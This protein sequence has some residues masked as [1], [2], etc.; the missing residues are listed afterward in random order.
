MGS[1]GTTVNKA[2]LLPTLLSFVVIFS[3]TLPASATGTS[4]MPVPVLEGYATTYL[5]ADSSNLGLGMAL[6]SPQREM[7]PMVAAGGYHTLGLKADG[8]VMAE[9]LNNFGQ[10]NVGNG[11]DLIQIAAGGYHTVE[12]LRPVQRGQLDGHHRSR[13]WWLSHIRA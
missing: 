9:G 8:K 1:R 10:C 3:F 2:I 4:S 13:R 5:E 12:R 7:I 6:N 11:I